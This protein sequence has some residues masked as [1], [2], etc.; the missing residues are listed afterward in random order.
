MPKQLPT[1]IAL[2]IASILA[3]ATSGAQTGTGRVTGV[4]RDT[5]GNPIEGARVSVEVQSRTLE[6]TT[7]DEGRWGILGFRNGSYTF[8][9]EAD[10]FSTYTWNAPVKQRGRNPSMEIILESAAAAAAAAGGGGNE[11]L[12]AANELYEAKSYPEALAKYDEALA[13]DPTLYQINLMIGNIHRDTGDLSKAK[14]HYQMVLDAEA[15]HTGALISLGDAYVQEGDFDKA[16]EYFEMAVEQ[17]TDAIVPFN[18]GEIYF[19]KGEAAKAVSYYQ[20]AADLKTDWADPHLRMGYAHLNTGDMAAA[21]IAFE[22]V[23]ELAPDSPHAQAA[24]AALDTLP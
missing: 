8:S 21:R 17:T 3:I 6:D 9:A 24:Q 23:V 18:V 12:D 14:E 5:Q 16:I 15:Q 2:S 11:V 22:K 7:D 20:R 1:L 10:G 13:S 4:V 19:N